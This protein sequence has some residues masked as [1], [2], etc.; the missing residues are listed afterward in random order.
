VHHE[1]AI[2]KVWQEPVLIIPAWIMKYYILDLSPHN[3]LVKYLIEQ[4]HTIF[5]ISWKNPRSEERDLG[6][7]DY[8]TLGVMAVFYSLK[9]AIYE[10][11]SVLKSYCPIDP[12]EEQSVHTGRLPLV[13][14]RWT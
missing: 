6:M 8:R 10:S 5:M 13:C 11:A 3:F 7:D 14:C 1:P 12:V 9:E 2:Q 4:G